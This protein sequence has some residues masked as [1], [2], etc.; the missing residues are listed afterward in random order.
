MVYPDVM[1][2]NPILVP[3]LAGSPLR[4]SSVHR[5][6]GA[7]GQASTIVLSGEFMIPTHS[8][9]PGKLFLVGKLGRMIPWVAISS[10]PAVQCCSLLE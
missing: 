1:S 4:A 2:V 7:G 10:A 6:G 5:E 3:G 9:V 8:C